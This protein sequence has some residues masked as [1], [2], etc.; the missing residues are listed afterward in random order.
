MTIAYCEKCGN[1]LREG[2]KFCHSCGAATTSSSF[3]SAPPPPSYASAQDRGG[4][5]P[6]SSPN[7]PQAWQSSN[8]E[9]PRKSNVG[10]IILITMAVILLL[11]G[12]VSVGAFIAI[13]RAVNNVVH[14][15]KDAAGNE[16]VSIS[17][18]GGSVRIGQNTAVTEAELGVPIYPG[19]TPSK[20]GS[21]SIS[22]SAAGK[23]GFV[24]VATFKTSDSV[25]EVADFY[26]AKLPNDTNVVDSTKFGNRTVVFKAK[27]EGGGRVITVNATDDSTTQITIVNAKGKDL[28]P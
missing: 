11:V 24:G 5:T 19:A 21:V 27:T 9:V 3:S 16:G 28:V 10:K 6:Q 13:R 23:S 20:D 14:V 12:V 4:Y 25:D 1:Q 18:P 22:G 7:Y 17:A 26:R 2:A 15:G 8:V